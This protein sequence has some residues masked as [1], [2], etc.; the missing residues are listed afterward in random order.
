M[1]AHDMP[2]RGIGDARLDPPADDESRV[3]VRDHTRCACG[4]YAVTARECTWCSMG[5]TRTRE[6]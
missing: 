3:P 5:L 2:D 4:R 1:T 6:G